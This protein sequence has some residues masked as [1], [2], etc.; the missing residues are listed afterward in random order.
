MSMYSLVNVLKR[1]VK[2]LYEYRTIY[3][4]VST[5]NSSRNLFPNNISLKLGQGHQRKYLQIA[6]SLCSPE[7]GSLLHLNTKLLVGR[8]LFNNLRLKVLP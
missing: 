3:L 5:D 1:Y 6:L 4:A 7:I 2:N 8:T